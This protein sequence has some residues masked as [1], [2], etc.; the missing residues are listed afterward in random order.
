MPGNGQAPEAD[1]PLVLV[2][3]DQREPGDRPGRLTGWAAE[4]GGQALELHPL[5]L[6]EQTDER[7]GDAP[8]LVT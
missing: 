5:P 8:V 7:A 2:A 3:V 4:R 1:H 6:S